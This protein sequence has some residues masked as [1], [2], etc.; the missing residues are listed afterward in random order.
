[1]QDA[2]GDD[3]PS[4]DGSPDQGNTADVVVPDADAGGGNVDAG[5]DRADAGTADVSDGGSLLDVSSGSDVSVEADS[6]SAV[7]ARLDVRDEPQCTAPSDCPP[8]A[9]ECWKAECVD[10]GCGAA[11]VAAG[12]PVFGQVAG[13]CKK[14]VCDGN[15]GTTDQNDDADV[16]DDSNACTL[17]GCSN[18]NP[19]HV[20]R[21]GQTCP[22]GLC[23]SSGQCVQC[24]T[25][26]DCSGSDDFCKKRKCD[27]GTCG[28]DLTQQGTALPSNLQTAG[29]C[30]TKACDGSGGVESDPAAGD[31]PNDQNPC[32]EDKCT[33][34]TP[35]NPPLPTGTACATGGGHVCDGSG[36]CVGCLQ[37]ADCGSAGQVCDT[38]LTTCVPTGTPLCTDYCNAIQPACLAA[39]QQYDTTAA[40]LHSCAPLPKT[41]TNALDC[42]ITHAG[43]AAGD[44]G[45]HCPH[46]GPGGDFVCGDPC[47]S[48]CTIAQSV[49]TGNN[50]QYPSV[51]DCKTACALFPAPTRY[52]VPNATGNTY[53]CRMYHLSLASVSA[54]SA[55]THCPHIAPVSAVCH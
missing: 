9:G 19:T 26:N 29:D 39:N 24:L 21:T 34:T 49:C 30:T 28:F 42:R 8:P 46:A 6:Q 44:P 31:V 51:S 32:T 12:T 13:D 5:S 15:G 38:G 27:N 33:G 55:V 35:S 18:G 41:G 36:A 50:Q 25:A 45:T 10:G 40:C 20:P 53:A 3:A 7:D 4:V 43:F 54:S 37:T 11:P 22:V 47:D 16:N 1:V 48:F 17:D 23:N 14:K 52:T 2:S